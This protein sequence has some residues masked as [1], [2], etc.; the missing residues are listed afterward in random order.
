MFTIISLCFWNY[1]YLSRTDCRW[2]SL[3]LY[4]NLYTYSC[5]WI[6]HS[7]I[8]KNILNYNVASYRFLFMKNSPRHLLSMKHARLQR[9]I[10]FDLEESYFCVAL[11]I[12]KSI[13]YSSFKLYCTNKSVIKNKF[14]DDTK[15]HCKAPSAFLFYFFFFVYQNKWF[16]IYKDRMW[17]MVYSF[18]STLTLIHYYCICQWHLEQL[19]FWNKACIQ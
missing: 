19:A 13:H 17:K 3:T 15:N 2:F 12:K 9:N 14:K 7:N 5:M 18:T 4:L 16:D 10:Y 1:R 6:H 8:Q 11:P